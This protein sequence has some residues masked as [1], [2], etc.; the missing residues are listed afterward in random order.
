[1]A[2]SRPRDQQADWMGPEKIFSKDISPPNPNKQEQLENHGIEV[3]ERIPLVVGVGDQNRSYL[4]TKVER[5]GHEIDQDK[6]V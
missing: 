6:L 2:D 4:E 3:A 1:M 5:M